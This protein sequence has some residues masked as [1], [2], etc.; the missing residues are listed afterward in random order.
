MARTKR[1]GRRRGMAP[2]H[3]HAAAIDIG[4][5]LHVA[6][7]GPD[8][9]P[10]PV[11]SFGTFTGDLRRLAD[12]LTQCGVTT[13]AMESTGVYWIPAYEILEQRGVEGRCAIPPTRC[14]RC[15]MLSARHTSATLRVTSMKFSLPTSS[16]R[17]RLTLPARRSTW[18][19]PPC[20]SML[21]PALRRTGESGVAARA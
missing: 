8:R 12:W 20:C 21:A 9:D 18:L 4:A 14:S 17:S 11:R 5:T 6:A 19:T 15:P 1:P 16:P 13:V 2:V 3:P 10:E 7:V